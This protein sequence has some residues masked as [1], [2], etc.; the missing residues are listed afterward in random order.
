MC[1][2]LIDPDESGW[3]YVWATVIGSLLG[4]LMLA[5]PW[6]LTF[7]WCFPITACP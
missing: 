1:A 6:V 7:G 4:F 5:I 3:F 2:P